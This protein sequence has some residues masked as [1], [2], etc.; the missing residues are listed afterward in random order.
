MLTI[1]FIPHKEVV[2]LDQ[3]KKIDKLLSIVK[4]DKIVILEGR[5]NAEEEVN[6][7]KKT[8]ENINKRF[9]GIELETYYHEPKNIQFLEKLRSSLAYLLLGYKHGLTIIG[10]A[11]II[12]EIRKDPTKIELLMFDKGKKRK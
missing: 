2:N 11:T 5:L 12:K 8:M 3:H 6:L 4:D 7:I 9:K 10:P 1:Q